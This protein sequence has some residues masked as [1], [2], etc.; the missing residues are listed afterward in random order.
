METDSLITRLQENMEESETGKQSCHAS[1]SLSSCV[2]AGSYRMYVIKDPNGEYIC[3]AKTGMKDFDLGP[4][5]DL[6]RFTKAVKISLVAE[7]LL[8][9]ALPISAQTRD[10]YF[11]RPYG[12]CWKRPTSSLGPDLHLETGVCRKPAVH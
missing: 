9:H 7:N 1:F 3:L 4:L 12:G 2:K 11:A 8:K 10:L 6:C 5:F